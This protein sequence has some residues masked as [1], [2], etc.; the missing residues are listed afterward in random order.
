MA[1]GNSI[2]AQLTR[3]AT[4]I[5]D[6]IEKKD[7]PAIPFA[8]KVKA[9][10]ALN[11][12]YAATKKRRGASSDDDDD[13]PEANGSTFENFREDIDRAERNTEN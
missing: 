10:T 4:H 12:Y 3:L 13:E 9:F 1:S 11:Q 2:K 7:G 6:E 5:V 8:E